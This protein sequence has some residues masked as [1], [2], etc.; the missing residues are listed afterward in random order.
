MVDSVVFLLT[1]FGQANRLWIRMKFEGNR[2][3]E[4]RELKVLVTSS[5]SILT[6]LEGV[7]VVLYRKMVLP[8]LLEMMIECKD[9]IAQQHIMDCLI[10]V[11]C[12]CCCLGRNDA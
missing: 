11:I 12:C 9:A 1:N 6:M 8:K 3:R 7:D 2:E 4:R 5:I 10:H